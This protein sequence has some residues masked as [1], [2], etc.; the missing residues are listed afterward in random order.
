MCLIGDAVIVALEERKAVVM[1]PSLGLEA[2]IRRSPEYVL[3]QVVRL[4]VREVDLPAQMA[5]FQPAD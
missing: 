5:Y 4:T 3:G 2:R 1:V